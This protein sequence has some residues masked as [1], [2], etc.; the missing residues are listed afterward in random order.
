MKIRHK[1][2]AIVASAT[3]AALLLAGGALIAWDLVRLRGDM[4]ADLASTAAI[5][6]EQSTAALSFEDREAA[7]ENLRSLRSQ[8]NV[9]AG[10]LYDGEGDLFATYGRKSAAERSCPAAT[11]PP[12]SRFLDG[13]AEL[14]APVV[15]GGKSIGSFYL[16]S[17][18]SAL[19][20]RQHAQLWTLGGALAVALA[21]G[22]LFSLRLQRFVAEP[23]AAL[24]ATAAAVSRD[25]DYSLRAERRTDDEVGELVEAFN[26]MLAQIEVT[27]ASLR[28]A[29]DELEAANAELRHEVEERERAEQEKADLLEREQAARHEAESANRLKDEFLATL[30]HELRTPL[31]AIL[32]WAGLLQAGKTDP[33]TLDRATV[34]IER[35]ALAQAQLVEDLL[36]VSRIITGKL[37]LDLRPVD[38]PAVLQTVADTVRPAA[39]AKR[40]TLELELEDSL[41]TL[42]CDPARLQQAIWNLVSNAVKFTPAEGRI[43][44]RARRR[45]GDVLIEVEDQGIGIDPAFLPHVFERFRQE[46]SSTTRVHGGL[47]LGLAIV[48][49]LVELHGGEVEVESPGPGRGAT[50]RIRLPVRPASMPAAGPRAAEAE[51]DLGGLHVLLVEDEADARELYGMILDAAGAAVTTA[52]SASEALAHFEE[53]PPDV[54]VSDIGLPGMDGYELM[55]RIRERSADRGGAVPAIALTAYAGKEHERR[56]VASGFQLHAAKPVAA[57]ELVALVHELAAS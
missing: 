39:E 4:L 38:L 31:N 44:V 33:E 25:N 55:R 1:L 24:A 37:S 57:A 20:Q 22:L 27:D 45:D 6:S 30:S 26:R 17:D 48:R 19:H 21:G 36:D 54:L 7:E 18:L 2:L 12:G 43:W 28:E 10:C 9:V 32:G 41:P 49:H 11:S 47:G 34:V 8:A 5:V 15:L 56:A 51:G 16:R 50:F 23:V 35:N 13:G 42:F 52:S 14:W 29:K 53:E 46:D 3:G 40:L